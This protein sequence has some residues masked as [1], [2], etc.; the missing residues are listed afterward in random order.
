M[1]HIDLI[2][3]R[4]AERATS[5]L[6]LYNAVNASADLV[7][8][9]LWGE[10]INPKTQCANDDAKDV[11]AYH[12]HL[13]LGARAIYYEPNGMELSNNPVSLQRAYHAGEIVSAY[14]IAA[15]KMLATHAKFSDKKF[16]Y[17]L[18]IEL[19][20]LAE[21]LM[22]DL[23]EIEDSRTSGEERISTE[24]ILK[25]VA[26]KLSQPLPPIC[27][28]ALRITETYKHVFICG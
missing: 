28:Q 5:P 18:S 22:G 10:V 20:D 15:K 25:V 3:T 12:E 19:Q 14:I 13:L 8:S 6:A 27:T 16:C 7:R 23:I 9:M 24:A 26:H 11:L 2:K 17:E 21:D 4:I 1:L